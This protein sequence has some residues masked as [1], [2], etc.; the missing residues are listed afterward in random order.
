MPHISRNKLKPEHFNRLYEE[1]LHSFERSFKNNSSRNVFYEFF[2]PTERVM[3][4]KRLAVIALLSKGASILTVSEAL[5][6]SQST[7]EKMRIKYEHGDY[8]K[9]IK[10]ALG[11][12][13]IW[14]ILEQIF[15]VGGLIPQK[16]GTDRWKKLNEDKR[17]EKLMNS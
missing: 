17:T 2:T 5:S 10:T 8:E 4:A 1:L 15:T 14:N 9:I 12:K 7:V 13:D 6:M 11:K 16:V 3:F